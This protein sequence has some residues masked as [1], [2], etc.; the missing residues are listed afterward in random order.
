MRKVNSLGLRVEGQEGDPAEGKWF[1]SPPTV[2]RMPSTV[3]SYFVVLLAMYF[4]A[5]AR[6]SFA[7]GMLSNAFWTR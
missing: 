2:Y 7:W 1:A 5:L 3:P 4:L 6:S